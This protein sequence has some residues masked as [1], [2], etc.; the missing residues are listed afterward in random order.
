MPVQSPRSGPRVTHVWRLFAAISLVVALLS[1]GLVTAQQPTTG[2]AL[3]SVTGE[4]VITRANGQ[5]EQ[6]KRCRLG[7]R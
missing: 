1:G 2:G 5:A 4:V 6:A 3:I 7:N